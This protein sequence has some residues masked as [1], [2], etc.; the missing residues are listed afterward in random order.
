[1][2]VA[3]AWIGVFL[4]PTA[5]GGSVVGGI[6]LYRALGEHRRS[7]P[8]AP[9][10]IERLAADLRRLHAKLEATENDMTGTRFKAARLR[11]LRGAYLDALCDACEQVGVTRPAVSRTGT[12]PLADIY[13][14]EAAL[15]ERHLDVRAR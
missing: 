10:P 13:R 5:V 6:R 2:G 15:R 14:V 7:V 12:V 8:A 11:A 4:L 1:M 9:E 3:L